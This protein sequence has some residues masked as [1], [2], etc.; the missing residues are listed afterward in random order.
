MSFVDQYQHE[1][2]FQFLKI[3]HRGKNYLV[4][5]SYQECQKAIKRFQYSGYISPDVGNIIWEGEE[6]VPQSFFDICEEMGVL[7]DSHTYD[8]H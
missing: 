7:A 4:L 6:D 8:V 2:K 5:A 3:N 1:N